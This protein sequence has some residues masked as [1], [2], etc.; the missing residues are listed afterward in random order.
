MRLSE[1]LSPYGEAFSKEKSPLFLSDCYRLKAVCARYFPLEKGASI[2]YNKS[3]N[4]DNNYK[5]QQGRIMMTIFS[6]E[7]FGPD[8]YEVAVECSI[9]KSLPKFSIIGL[10]D[11][12]IKESQLRIFTG[13]E[14]SGVPIPP[15]EISIKPGSRGQEKSGNRA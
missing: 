7:V 1:L 12:A 4:N 9:K 15:A 5:N 3:I 6:A 14:N 10:P 2:W 11:A 8:G 13:A